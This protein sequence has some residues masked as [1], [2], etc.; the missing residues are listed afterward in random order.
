MNKR[1]RILGCLVG[2]AL[3]DAPGGVAE[4]GRIC[5]SDDTQLTLA[6]CKAIQKSGEVSPATIAVEFVRWFRH[7]AFT[8]CRFVNSKGAARPC[9][10]RTLCALRSAGEMTAG[11]GAAMR[12]APRAF[13]LDALD[14]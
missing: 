11:N 4:R 6:T 3:G 8:K 12:I 5:L 10:W 13:L 9:R 2:G 7:G 1:D 14:R